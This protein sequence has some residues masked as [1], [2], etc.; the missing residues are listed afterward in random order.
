MTELGLTA[1]TRNWLESVGVDVVEVVDRSWAGSDTRVVQ[2]HHRNGGRSFLKQF[3]CL[4]KFTREINAYG[5]WLAGFDGR[6]PRLRFLDRQGLRFLMSDGGE[7]CC[8]WEELPP[9]RQES[10]QYLAG[11]FLRTLHEVEFVDD[12]ELRIGDAV[13]LR[14]RA[15]QRRIVERK[16]LGLQDAFP[17]TSVEEV[18]R[19]VTDIEEIVPLLNRSKRVPCHRDFWKRNWIWSLGED[20]ATDEMRLSVIDFEHARPDLF[21]FDM[22]KNWSDAWLDSERQESAFWDG[23]GRT[24][25]GDERLLLQRCGALHALQTI[26]W[27][28]EHQQTEFL[29]QGKALMVAATGNG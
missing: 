27:A 3:K 20:E 5:N 17:C 11:G 19:I 12:D 16:A 22:M 9:D 1:G 25:E 10:L 7:C 15:T 13:L 2:L 6:V 29:A 24:L 4:D 21:V 18:T 26:L 8:S 28:S 14:A 23:Y